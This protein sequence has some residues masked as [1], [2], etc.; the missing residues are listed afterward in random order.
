MTPAII[1]RM[2]DGRLRKELEFARGFN[3]AD[4]DAERWR[5]HI[6]AEAQRR[7]LRDAK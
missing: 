6:E 2:S 1:V 7:S 4:A 5:K 3:L